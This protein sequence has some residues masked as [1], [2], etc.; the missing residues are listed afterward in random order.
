MQ[1]TPQALSADLP[2]Q[3]KSRDKQAIICLVLGIVSIIFSFL[4]PS[5]FLFLPYYRDLFPW[6]VL[7]WISLYGHYIGIPIAITGLIFFVFGRKATVR[8]DLAIAGLVL[9][10]VSLVD[11][12]LNLVYLILVIIAF[13]TG[14]GLQ[15]GP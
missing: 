13:A 9:C 1:S 14:G 7:H 8:R 4:A 12:F 3:P 15:P 5:M 11:S 10:I 6:S 2:Q